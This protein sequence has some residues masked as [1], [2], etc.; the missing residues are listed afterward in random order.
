VFYKWWLN[1]NL[2]E[3]GY[4]H[5][6][7]RRNYRDW[8]GPHCQPDA[9]KDWAHPRKDPFLRDAAGRIKTVAR[10]FEELHP[11]DRYY[12]TNVRAFGLKPADVR[13]WADDLWLFPYYLDK[14]RAPFDTQPDGP[15][16]AA[17]DRERK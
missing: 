10:L 6:G 15:A 1:D 4:E 12:L 3:Y 9:G 2:N 7:F 17:Y 14:Q 5:R 13:K 16:A 8:D 11:K